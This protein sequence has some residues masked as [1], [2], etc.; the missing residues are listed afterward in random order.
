ML[1]KRV[2]RRRTGVFFSGR[3]L[4]GAR[5]CNPLSS[6]ISLLSLSLSLLPSRPPLSLTRTPLSTNLARSTA[7]SRRDIWKGERET[8][9]RG[10][11]TNR[12]ESTKALASLDLDKWEW[13]FFSVQRAFF[14]FLFFLSRGFLFTFFLGGGGGWGLIS[15]APDSKLGLL[16][17]HGKM[18]PQQQKTKREF[19]GLG[20]GG[21]PGGRGGRK[22]WRREE[23]AGA[24][25]SKTRR[26]G[27]TFSLRFSLR[28]TEVRGRRG[29]R[30]ARPPF[31]SRLYKDDRG[32]EREREKNNSL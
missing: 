4:S 26:R 10:Y 5:R 31:A 20:G 22:E 24:P 6:F 12:E 23:R 21:G 7:F 30:D 11:E 19:D 13:S 3:C 2:E 29:A 15:I 8:T 9:G 25:A 18:K 1:R 17:D 16:W 28:G 27:P 32:R 14:R